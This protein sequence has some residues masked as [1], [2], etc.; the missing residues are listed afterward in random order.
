M[1]KSIQNISMSVDTDRAVISDIVS[2]RF[3]D[4]VVADGIEPSNNDSCDCVIPNKRKRYHRF[5]DP[6]EDVSKP[7]KVRIS[8]LIDY[9]ESDSP[10]PKSEDT[11][12]ISNRQTFSFLNRIKTWLYRTLTLQRE[13]STWL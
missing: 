10:I 4:N 13:D 11:Q 9:L 12:L 3:Y 1:R 7:K 8:N 5:E 6:C 2:S